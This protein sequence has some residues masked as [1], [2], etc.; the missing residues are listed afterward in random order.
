MT[1]RLKYLCIDWGG[2][3]GLDEKYGVKSKD[4]PTLMIIGREGRILYGLQG[5]Y[6]EKSLKTLRTRIL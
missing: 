3:L 6:S 1:N 2:S 5:F 4:V